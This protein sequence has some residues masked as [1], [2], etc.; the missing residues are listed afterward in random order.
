MGFKFINSREYREMCEKIA[1]LEAEIIEK[2][3]EIEL[4]HETIMKLK[5]QVVSLTTEN[6]LLNERLDEAEGKK[7]A[8]TEKAKADKPSVKN[9]AEP[10]ERKPVKRPRAPRKTKKE[11]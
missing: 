2:A 9:D 1:F 3:R 7:K 5:R 8:K 10:A 6:G 4:K 11:D